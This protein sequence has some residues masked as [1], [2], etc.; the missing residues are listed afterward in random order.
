MF[1][2]GVL[3]TMVLTSRSVRIHR[4]REKHRMFRVGQMKG[5]NHAAVLMRTLH[6]VDPDATVDVSVNARMVK[7]GSRLFAVA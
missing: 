4:L 3:G 7:T 5:D 2:V 1:S 6:T